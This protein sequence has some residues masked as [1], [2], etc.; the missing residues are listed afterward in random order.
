M[1]ATIAF[2]LKRVWT[3]IGVLFLAAACQGPASGV[4]GTG[5]IG[6]PASGIG[7]GDVL[8]VSPSIGGS[9]C[10]LRKTAQPS[11][12]LEQFDVYCAGW[13]EPSGTFWRL[14]RPEGVVLR[15][16]LEDPDLP[17]WGGLRDTCEPLAETSL[18]DGQPAL[19]ATCL[20]LD[21]WPETVFAAES[22]GSESSDNDF[23]LLGRGMPHLAPVFEDALAAMEGVRS[24]PE[25]RRAGTK[26]RMILLAEQELDINGTLLTL[27]DVQDFRKLSRL[28]MAYN[29]AGDFISAEMAHRN[30]LSLQ[31]KLLGMEH[32]ALGRTIATIALNVSNQ[33]HRREAANLFAEAEPLAQKGTREAYAEYL[34]YRG[35][36]EVRTGSPEVGSSLIAR[37]RGLRQALHGPDSLEVAYS[38]YLEG[39]ALGQA[40]EYAGAADLLNKAL[41]LFGQRA[42]PEWTAFS[43]DRLAEYNRRLGRLDLART[44]AARA[45]EILEAVFG[46]GVRLSR[47]LARQAHIERDAGR[48]DAALQLYRRAMDTALGDRIALSYLG[49]EDVAPYLDLLLES[50]IDD[51]AQ[52]AEA[53][54][55]AQVPQERTTAKAVKLMA[56]RLVGSDPRMPAAA[57]ALQDA[58]ALRQEKQLRLARAQFAPEEERDLEAEAGLRAELRDAVDAVA[59]LER[60]LQAQF[61]AYGQLVAPEILDAGAIAGILRPGEALLQLVVSNSATYAL[62]VGSDGTIRAHRAPLGAEELE[63]SVSRLREGVDWLT[64]SPAFDLPS[65]HELYRMLFGALD[66]ELES[67]DHLL[68]VPQGALLSLPPALLVRRPPRDGDYRQAGW[69]IRDV[70][71]S[72]LPSVGA[73]QQLREAAR[74]SSASRPFLGIGDPVFESRDGD[75]GS[76]QVAAEQCR[77]DERVDPALLRRLQ[78]L[79]ETRA[80]LLSIAR[81][82]GADERDLVLADAAIE[83]TVRGL[84]LSDYRVVVLATHGLLPGELR[85]QA[86]PALVLTPPEAASEADDGLLDASEVALMELDADWVVL[87]ACN[88]GGPGS[89]LGGAS[90]SGLARAFFYAG[91]RS[92]LVS[93]W[94]VASEPTVILTTT[95]F[96]NFA[97]Q[98]FTGKAEALR[99]AQLEMIARADMAHPAFWA[100]FTLVGDGGMDSAGLMQAR[101][102]EDPAASP[103]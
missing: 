96:A 74:P 66:A 15:T 30:A 33:G 62:M 11:E 36:H 55:V 49:V 21:G 79:P 8:M 19:I 29:H 4:G 42:D 50:S 102:R 52:L 76:L 13:E 34:A 83:P 78:P 28:A 2:R 14:R 45:T 75:S 40:G 95:S 17:L 70:A 71:I 97:D 6:A 89:E 101:L 93:H 72:V 27:E 35:M 82:L 51:P 7:L 12:L 67:I 98:G 25:V 31:E 18:G 23:I 91:A 60:D 94:V 48:R 10:T 59:R 37:S 92:L 68:Y 41:I 87:S 85:C 39:D 90:L 100:A 57:R 58:I 3:S 80:E 65:S 103:I 53:F 43:L 56:A 81:S 9:Q 26:S 16:L 47:G 54:R 44:Q 77:V 1:R 61:P 20:A 64:G 69:L 24:A 86:E 99:Q 73:V 63:A 88:T 32:P 84:L 5:R 46:H 22:V 38:Y